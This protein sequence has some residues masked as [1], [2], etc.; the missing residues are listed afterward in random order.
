MKIG[1]IAVAA[2]LLVCLVAH[3]ALAQSEPENIARSYTLDPK[4]GMASQLED[5]MKAHIAWRKQHND[6]WTWT[7]FQVVNG[8]NFGQYL[9]RSG[10]HRWADLDA[11][12]RWTVTTEANAHFTT[13]VGPYLESFTSRITQVNSNLS[14]FPDDL[15][16]MTLYAVTNFDVRLPARFFGAVRAIWT[17]PRCTR[18]A[19]GSCA[20]AT[21]RLMA[22]TPR[23]RRPPRPGRCLS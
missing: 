19:P 6:P 12:D 9:V 11:Y 8:D 17:S 22:S 20:A 14:R 5:A 7:V 2:G 10:N 18:T 16:G 21:A 23:G 1:L 3:P 13:T 4:P 15:S